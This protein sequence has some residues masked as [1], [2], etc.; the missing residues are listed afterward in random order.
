M[1]ILTNETSRSRATQRSLASG[2]TCGQVYQKDYMFLV[3]LFTKFSEKSTQKELNYRKLIVLKE[4]YAKI[5]GQIMGG[6]AMATIS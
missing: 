6:I 5:Q 2:S 4:E 1:Y 3:L